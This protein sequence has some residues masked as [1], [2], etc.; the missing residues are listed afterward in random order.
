MNATVIL[1][2]PS[3]SDEL[4]VK[5][6]RVDNLGAVLENNRDNTASPIGL[7]VPVTS[8]NLKRYGLSIKLP[9]PG[10]LRSTAVVKADG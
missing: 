4:S 3:H 10:V 7:A 9:E 2:K 6:Q 8:R 5:V 1:R